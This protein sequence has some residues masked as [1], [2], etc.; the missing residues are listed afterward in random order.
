MCN[1]LQL[2][3]KVCCTS[4]YLKPQPYDNGTCYTYKTQADDNCYDLSV[5]WSVTQDELADFNDSTTWGWKGCGD[6]GAGVNICLSDGNPPLPALL[7]NAVCGPQA[8]GTS[9]EG[10]ITDPSELADLN[11]CPLNSCRNI[12]GHCGID[13]SFCTVSKGPTGNPGT[14]APNVFGCISNCG[15]DVVNNEEGPSARYQRVRYYETFNWD[16]P[17]LH[18]RAE[19]SNTLNYTHMHW[20]FEDISEDLSIYVNDTHRQWDGFMKLKNVKKIVSFGGWGSSTEGGTY[21]IFRKA[22]EPKFRTDFVSNIVAFAEETGAD[23]ID[24]DWE[25]PGVS[26]VYLTPFPFADRMLI[27]VHC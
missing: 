19:W 3:Q 11:P 5:T 6:L 18:M 25:Y 24:I 20:A 26:S 15:T 13:S 1:N 8:P 17:C 21:G 10:S 14:S 27:S 16:R 7:P 23:G 22:M 9:I 4:G 12:W 2:G